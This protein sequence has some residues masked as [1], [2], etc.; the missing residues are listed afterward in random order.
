MN[1]LKESNRFLLIR[2]YFFK[3]LR[4]R[5]SETRRNKEKQQHNQTHVFG[6]TASVNPLSERRR[7]RTRSWRDG[8]CGSQL[9]K[10]LNT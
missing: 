4:T 9:R 2:K 5:A 8:G 7:V 3:L 1:I 6:A 10:Q